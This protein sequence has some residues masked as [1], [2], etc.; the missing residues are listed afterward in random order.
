[1]DYRD[2][3]A[4]SVNRYVSGS[5]KAHFIDKLRHTYFLTCKPRI[6]VSV[7]PVALGNLLEA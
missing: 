1:M 7:K 6:S 5:G 4:E 3:S 2:A